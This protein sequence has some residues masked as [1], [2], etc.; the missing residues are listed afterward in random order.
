MHGLTTLEAG[1]SADRRRSAGRARRRVRAVATLVC[2]ALG[3]LML[4]CASAF[5]GAADDV[6][7]LIYDSAEATRIGPESD[8]ARVELSGDGLR[9][10]GRDVGTRW[11]PEGAGP[12]RVGSRTVRGRIAVRAEDGR[13]QV[14]NRIAIEDY[15]AST[16]GGEMSPSWPQEALRAQAVAARTYVLHEAAKRRSLDFDVRATAASQVYRGIG[17]ETPQTR[18]A[19]EATRGEVLTFRGEPILAVFHSTAGGRTAT[20]AEVWGEDRPYLKSVEVEEEEDAPHTYWRT[21]FT[22]EDLGRVFAA[23]GV[24]ADPLDGIAVTRRTRSG[25]VERLEL[26]SG[27]R[28]EELRGRA[29]RDLASSLGLRSTLFDVKTT[30][31]GFAFVGSGYGHGVGMS[32]W[33]ARAMAKRGDA[34]PRILA[35]FYPGTRL[36]R[37]STRSVAAPFNRAAAPNGAAAPTAGAPP[38]GAGPADAPEEGAPRG[39]IR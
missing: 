19:A 33:G 3:G 22:R 14:L 6:R 31:D 20:A 37:W 9:V 34:Y 35:R 2:V 18:A 1:R 15:V 7:V 28:V 13:I 17:A 4:G 16:V 23:D 26:R 21:E 12:W 32:Q 25:R 5:A 8:P 36:V 38:V 27:G 11:R 39:E 10:D 29:V 24:A 30:R